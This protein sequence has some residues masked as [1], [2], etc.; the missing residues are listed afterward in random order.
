MMAF[1]SFDPV[2]H[3]RAL[4]GEDAMPAPEI[5]R[6]STLELQIIELA[7]REHPASARAPGKLRRLMATLFGLPVPNAL[8]DP[9]LESLRRTAVLAWRHN[10]TVSKGF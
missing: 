4:H 6:L 9:E 10:A 2:T 3:H 5:R 7:R 1:I 8:A